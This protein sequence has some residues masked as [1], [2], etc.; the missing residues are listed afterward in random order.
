M[1]AEDLKQPAVNPSTTEAPGKGSPS[2]SWGSV[3]A[4]KGCGSDFSAAVI[5]HY[6]HK[7]RTEETVYFDLW[8]QRDEST[9]TGCRVTICRHGSRNTEG[10]H[11]QSRV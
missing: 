8:F 9:L 2:A 10:S 5:K 11:L 1:S 7:Q 6:K 4:F 3:N